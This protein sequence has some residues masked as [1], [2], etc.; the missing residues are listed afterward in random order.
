MNSVNVENAKMVEIQRE[1]ARVREG[2]VAQMRGSS[3]TIDISCIDVDQ[4]PDCIRSNGF[5]YIKVHPLL[6]KTL[7]KI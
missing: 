3:V 6:S 2:I 1:R 7:G 4:M 5:V